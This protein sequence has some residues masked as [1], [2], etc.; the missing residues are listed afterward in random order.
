L[1][2]LNLEKK[3]QEEE[4]RSGC[5]VWRVACG[6]VCGAWY[7][8]CGMWYVVCGMWYVVCGMWYVVCGVWY[9]VCSVSVSGSVRE[10]ECEKES[11]LQTSK[12]TLFIYLLF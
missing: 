2:W 8:V 7:V 5:R 10:C 11:Y 4:K 1:T 12:G 6:V 9:V 3:I